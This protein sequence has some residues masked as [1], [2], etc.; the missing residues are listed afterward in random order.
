VP[1]WWIAGLRFGLLAL[2]E[3][4]F[5]NVLT[6][7]GGSPYAGFRE[8]RLVDTSWLDRWFVWLFVPGGFGLLALVDPQAFQAWFLGLAQLPGLDAHGHR[9]QPPDS[10]RSFPFGGI[11][12]LRFV[13]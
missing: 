10:L 4:R 5:A 6:L 7:L 13:P 12:R 9:V 8:K 11:V 1:E 3:V 2:E